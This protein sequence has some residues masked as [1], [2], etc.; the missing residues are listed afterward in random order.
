M[1]LFSFLETTGSISL[2]RVRRSKVDCE[3]I[4]KEVFGMTTSSLTNC[5][6]LGILRL[7]KR[8]RDGGR[9]FKNNLIS[10]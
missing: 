5:K 9:A 10:H 1:L 7:F 4:E 2:R 8:G 3:L 6:P